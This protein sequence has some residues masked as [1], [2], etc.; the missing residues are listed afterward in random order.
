MGFTLS[1]WNLHSLDSILLRSVI[2]ISLL[3]QGK[4]TPTWVLYSTHYLSYLIPVV[5]ILTQKTNNQVMSIQ[6]LQH[7]FLALRLLSS[8]CSRRGSLRICETIL[9]LS[10]L[11]ISTFACMLD[12]DNYNNILSM[13]CWKTILPYQLRPL[14][15]VIWVLLA[16]IYSSQRQKCSTLWLDAY[17]CPGK[18]QTGGLEGS[19]K[20]YY[21]YLICHW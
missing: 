12:E 2:N 15:A 7:G 3:W 4:N 8:R 18:S 14:G 21:A 5:I 13:K 10:S 9:C 16:F 19:L 1:G 20:Y 17:G 6:S 11:G